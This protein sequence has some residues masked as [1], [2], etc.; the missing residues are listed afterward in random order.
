MNAIR[1]ARLAAPVALTAAALAQG[2]DFLLTYSQ[3]ETTLSGSAGTVL[4]F[5]NPNEIAHLNWSNGPCASLSAEKWSPRTCFNTMA[6]DE[7]SDGWYWNP[8]IFNTIDA[9]MTGIST[10]PVAGGANPRTVFYS[11]SVAMGTGV[12]GAPGLR[13][14]DVGR[15]IR[16]AA[17]QDGQVEYFMTQEQFNT[18]LGLPLTTAI[19]VDAIAFAPGFGVYFSLD[20]DTFAFTPCGP[21]FVQDGAVLHVPN[22]ALTYTTDFRVASVLPNSAS[23]LYTEAQ[24]SAFLVNAQI[25]DRFGN[26]ISNLIDTESL[27]IDWSGVITTVVPCP[28]NPI[29]TPELIFS[30][31]TMT[32]AGLATTAL[33]GAIYQGMCGAAAR[34][35]GGGPTFGPQMGIQPTSATVGAPSYVNS[36]A[37]TFT[38]RYSMEAQQHTANTMFGLPFGWQ[39]LHISSPEPWNFIIWTPAPNGVNA[40]TPSMTNPFGLL[41]FPD[42][43]PMPNFFAAA[44]T[45]G[46]FA[47][48]PLMAISPGFVGKVVFQSLCFPTNGTWEFS[49][50]VTLE[51]F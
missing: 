13:P 30:A 35:C 12:S 25:S 17:N 45:I 16:N 4:Q 9:L 49:T 6:G 48:C 23:V 10:S 21:T 36:I 38:W 3:A 31:E 11:P 27:E 7:N 41:C 2:P 39:S 1:L 51:L 43:Y 26:C 32:G 37:S 47:T 8:A 34:G 22:S 14:G 24:M 33:G 28:G 40:V 20:A 5:L 29:S 42:F 50:P 19:D 46:G 15:I 18:S 44:P